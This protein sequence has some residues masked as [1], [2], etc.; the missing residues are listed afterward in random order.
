MSY[1]ALA[2]SGKQMA[3]QLRVQDNRGGARNKASKALTDGEKVTVRRR[4]AQGNTI[5]GLAQIYGVSDTQITN[6]VK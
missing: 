1:M 5:R 4:H 2:E 3:A 6:A